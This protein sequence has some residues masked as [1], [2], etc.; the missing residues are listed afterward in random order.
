MRPP[1][2][3]DQLLVLL[4]AAS[5]ALGLLFFIAFNL[6][7]LLFPEALPLV[8]LL[9]VGLGL[10]IACDRVGKP[11]S[12]LA[13]GIGV[14]VF[15]V[16]GFAGYGKDV[17]W[18]PQVGPA[19]IGTVFILLALA[20]A[21]PAGIHGFVTSRN[22]GRL[23]SAREGWLTRGGMLALVA[24][25]LV[26]GGALAQTISTNALQDSP[27]ASS[28]FDFPPDATVRLTTRDVAY[29]PR[30]FTVPAG[31]I[32]EIAITN[33]DPEAHDFTYEVGGKRF[34]HLILPGGET[35]FLVRLDAAGSIPYRC[36]PHSQGYAEDD[37]MT[38]GLTVV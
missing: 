34:T 35:A 36:T 23:P 15:P 11:W 13:G 8:G 29:H 12:Y 1:R 5:A 31:R 7:V 37:G 22:G 20:L 32:V 17:I 30:E 19:W 16:L 26:L 9:L 4:G 38:G 25:S 2:T 21:L 10:A 33:E 18:N 6:R 14:S 24:I 3:F 28:G 27:L